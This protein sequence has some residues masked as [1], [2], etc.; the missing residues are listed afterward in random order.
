M[1]K[2]WNSNKGKSVAAQLE[3]MGRAPLCLL[4][5]VFWSKEF[6]KSTKK[7]TSTTIKAG[8]EFLFM[9]ELKA[10]KGG[11]VMVPVFDQDPETNAYTYACDQEIKE[12]E[13]MNIPK[14]KELPS[15]DDVF[16]I[17]N[18]FI[19]RSPKETDK[20][21]LLKEESAATEAAPTDEKAADPKKLAPAAPSEAV[22]TEDG[23]PSVQSETGIPASPD[24]GAAMVQEAPVAKKVEYWYNWKADQIDPLL[25][26]DGVRVKFSGAA[27]VRFGPCQFSE[28]DESLTF[29]LGE[30]EG[31]G[32]LSLPEGQ[33]MSDF[34]TGTNGDK[35]IGLMTN[36]MV[37]GPNGSFETK[38]KLRGVSS[39]IG[40]KYNNSTKGYTIEPA[41]TLVLSSWKAFVFAMLLLSENEVGFTGQKAKSEGRAS[42]FTRMGGGRVVANDK[43]FLCEAQLVVSLPKDFP[44]T[45]W[46]SMGRFFRSLIPV[47]P[48][49][50]AKK[51][52]ELPKFAID[53]PAQ[54]PAGVCLVAYNCAPKTSAWVESLHMHF[55][56]IVAPASS[57]SLEKHDELMQEVQKMLAVATPTNR[58]LGDRKMLSADQVAAAV[59]KV[60]G[61]DSSRDLRLPIMVIFKP[62]SGGSE[63]LRGVWDAIVADVYSDPGEE[64][65]HKQPTAQA[66]N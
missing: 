36:F 53:P 27:N 13:F 23:A 57:H 59:A 33:S 39:L 64:L 18:L 8:L 2:N 56:M 51:I 12:S 26:E 37:N 31:A 3:S 7:G 5:R 29:A 9:D 55:Y 21:S 54:F 47:D 16:Y 48:A 34:V 45:E 1:S 40:N 17:D 20:K 63:A 52:N 46:A 14:A 4:A 62:S 22:P 32:C 38:V 6:V 43:R 44:D 58:G 15:R 10:I 42:K 24:T 11:S 66:G 30:G 60:G 19:G 35:D 25:D 28:D 49:T 41:D 65:K 61:K 50:C